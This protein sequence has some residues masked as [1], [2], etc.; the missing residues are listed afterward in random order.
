M[1]RPLET[2]QAVDGVKSYKLHLVMVG[3]L[4]GIT[5]NDLLNKAKAEG[6]Q[7]FHFVGSVY[8]SQKYDYL[9]AAD[10]YVSFSIRENF[11]HTAAESMSAALP[12]ILSKGNDLGPIVEESGTGWYL[13]EDSVVALRSAIEDL[14]GTAADDL[15][16][17]GDSGRRLVAS[18]FSFERFR[19]RLLGFA[20]KY[21]RT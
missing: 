9:F 10:A 5:E 8:G 14:M 13:K 20:Q 4:E 7:N 16:K 11:N 2:I 12:V 19:D 17:M 21:A 6:L 1:K 15:K 18:E 3:P